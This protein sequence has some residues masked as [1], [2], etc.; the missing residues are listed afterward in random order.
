MA[1]PDAKTV[2]EAVAVFSLIGS[3][4]FNVVQYNDGNRIQADAREAQSARE[5]SDARSALYES[6][7]MRFVEYERRIRA[8]TEDVRAHLCESPVDASRASQ[9]SNGCVAADQYASGFVRQ[10][11]AEESE[12]AKRYDSGYQPTRSAAEAIAAYVSCSESV[13]RVLEEHVRRALNDNDATRIDSLFRY[14]EHIN[15]QWLYVKIQEDAN[16]RQTPNGTEIA[17]IAADTQVRVLALDR[18]ISW[19]KIRLPNSDIEGWVWNSLVEI[20]PQSLL[21]TAAV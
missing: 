20:P 12:Y 15:E 8:L 13:R 3:L 5:G 4:V 7:E 11:E 16:V 21:G 6:R 17:Q 1:R 2:I 14:A 10:I 18:S 9:V 19:I